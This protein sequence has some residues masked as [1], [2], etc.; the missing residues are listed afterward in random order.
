METKST[1]SNHNLDSLSW[2]IINS[3]NFILK[4]KLGIINNSEIFQHISYSCPPPVTQLF[5]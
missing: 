5:Y 4:I 2:F 3:I 1:Y